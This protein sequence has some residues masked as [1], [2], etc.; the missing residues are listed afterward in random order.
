MGFYLKKGVEF[1]SFSKSLSLRIKHFLFFSEMSSSY[2]SDKRGRMQPHPPVPPS[3]N[4]LGI[5]IPKTTARV[6]A[7]ATTVIIIICLRSKRN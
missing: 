7:A 6:A 5:M 1:H 4:N 3:L 2:R